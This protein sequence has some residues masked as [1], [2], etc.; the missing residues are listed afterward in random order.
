MGGKG[1]AFGRCVF[2]VPHLSQAAFE[3]WVFGLL[4]G[5]LAPCYTPAALRS[6]GAF[7]LRVFGLLWG[8]G[9]GYAWKAPSSVAALI[10]MFRSVAFFGDIFSFRGTSSRVPPSFRSFSRRGALLSVQCWQVCLVHTVWYHS[11]AKHD[12]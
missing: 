5:V 1:G 2:S 6:D 4:R 3:V 12:V 8:G 9:E 7:K 10:V 11:S